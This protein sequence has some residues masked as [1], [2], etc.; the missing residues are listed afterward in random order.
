MLVS[1]CCGCEDEPV[2]YDG[3]NFADIGICPCCGEHCVFEEEEVYCP[4]LYDPDV[5]SDDF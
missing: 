2:G 4:G 1:D 5:D 3:P